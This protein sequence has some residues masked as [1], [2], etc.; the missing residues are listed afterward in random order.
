MQYRL[1]ELNLSAGDKLFL[2]T[3]G[4]PEACNKNNEMFTVERTIQALNQ[5]KGASPGELL[6][7]VRTSIA[8]FVKDGEQ[9]DDLTMMCVEYMG[10]E[11]E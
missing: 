4:V 1:S 11:K 9:F 7:N 6:N 5:D 2:Y 3:D 8:C 10:I